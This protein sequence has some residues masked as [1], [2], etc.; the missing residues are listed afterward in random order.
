LET[1]LESRKERERKKLIERVDEIDVES[2]RDRENLR[3]R[4]REGKKDRYG[5]IGREWKKGAMHDH[6]FLFLLHH[7]IRRRATCVN[8]NETRDTWQGP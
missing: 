7:V 3:R 6:F 4:M 1:E 8:L 5:D 2:K